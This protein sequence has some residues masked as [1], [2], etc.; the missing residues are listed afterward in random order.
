MSV[1][2]SGDNKHVN[3]SELARSL[4]ESVL[5]EFG[6]CLVVVVDNVIT[7]KG[8]FVQMGKFLKIQVHP[9]AK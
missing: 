1:C 5:L 2:S 8:V 9:V 6:L 3:V 7:F 4:M